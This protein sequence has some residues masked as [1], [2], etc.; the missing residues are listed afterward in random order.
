MNQ[1]MNNEIEHFLYGQGVDIVRFVDISGLPPE[2]THGFGKAVLF[3][4][5]LSKEF[6]SAVR[7]GTLAGDDEFTDKEKETDSIADRLAAYLEGKSCRA[8]SQSEN[9]IEENGDYDEDTMASRLPHKT[10]ARLAGLGCIG[11]NNLLITE[12]YGCAISMCAVLTDAPVQT[13]EH[14]LLPA[15]C[16]GCD[17]CRAVCPGHAILGAEWTESAGRDAIVDVRKC[18]CPLKCVVNCPFTLEYALRSN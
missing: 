6:I 7:D 11:K 13:E 15:K 17:I 5:A 1:M 8:R 12:E 10:I 2:Q 18:A 3:C 4:M 16:G 9:S 14:P